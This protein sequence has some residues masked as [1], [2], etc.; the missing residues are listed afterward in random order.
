MP[1]I[2]PR[3]GRGGYRL[4]PSAEAIARGHRPRLSIVA[5]SQ[6]LHHRA[7]RHVVLVFRRKQRAAERDVGPMVRRVITASRERGHMDLPAATACYDVIEVEGFD[8]A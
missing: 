3:C 4:R 5:A 8:P 2:M 7:V 6:S 1:R